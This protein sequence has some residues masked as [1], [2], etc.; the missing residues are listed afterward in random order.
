[1]T[2][3]TYGELLSGDTSLTRYLYNGRCGV[4]TD[5]NG[6]YYMRQ[7]YYN[8]EIKRFVNQD[9][10]R[11]SI[12]NSQSLNRYSYVQ[13]NPV[14]YTDP[15]GLSP[16]SGLFADT[17]FAHSVLGLLGCIP[18]PVGILANSADAIIYFAV[19]HDYLMATVSALD[20]VSMGATGK[21]AKAVGK[22]QKISKSAMYLKVT[23]SLLSNTLSFGKNTSMAGENLHKM[24]N[25]YIAGGHTFDW[26]DSETRAECY[27]LCLNLFGM[28]MSG[29]GM[30]KEGTDFGGMLW[31]DGGVL[32]SKISSGWNKLKQGA[33]DHLYGN[34][35]D[36]GS[37]SGNDTTRVG[38]WMS[39]DE[40]DKM[41]AS[42]KVQMSGDNKV[43]VANPA[44]INAFGKQAPKGSIYVEFDVPSNTI[45]KGG[46][47]GWGIING[48]G[49]LLDRLNAKKGLPRITE[50]P[51][52]TNISIEGSK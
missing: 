8:P 39:Q 50:M 28:A 26:N 46:K 17:S 15:F 31:Q 3:G 35:L 25:K 5:A 41:V 16:I 48:P 34:R 23:T 14:S 24:Y 1:Y 44:D 37:R 30:Y 29:K 7:R 32:K 43:H 11:G 22:G 4:S 33:R 27:N 36:G 12:G 13:G 21:I 9:V 18:G 10:V 49:S 40:Y 38:R 2:Y 20:A 6:L 47:D 51:N 45:S 52:A 42:G 19:D